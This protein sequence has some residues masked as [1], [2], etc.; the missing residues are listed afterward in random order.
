SSVEL[1]ECFT[2]SDVAR[3]EATRFLVIRD[4]EAVQFAHFGRRINQYSASESTT[5]RTRGFDD[6]LWKMLVL[7]LS[8]KPATE[9][10]GVAP[11]TGK[12][13][14]GFKSVFLV[15]D[16][17]RILSGRLAFEVTGGV[18]PRRL[19]GAE[20]QTLDRTRARLGSG[21]T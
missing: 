16:R 5:A 9:E 7:S 12:F 10:G 18:Y 4:G 20:R 13:G 8:N 14:L 11:V 2:V 6:D 3:R 15:S 17:P 19:V 1:V 21:Q